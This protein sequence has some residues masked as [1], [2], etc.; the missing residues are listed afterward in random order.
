MDLESLRTFCLL[1]E[2]DSFTI[3]ARELGITE[4]T[5]SYRIKELEKYLDTELII[6]KRDRTIY[7]TERSIEL[8]EKSKG[9]LEWLDRF[10]SHNIRKPLKG[11]IKISSG[12]VAG[13]YFLASAVKDFRDK[14]PEVEI[15]LDFCSAEE[16]FTRLQNRE[17]DLGFSTSV[18]FKK[19]RNFINSTKVTEVFPIELIVI[20]PLNHPV[21][22]Y[23]K[24]EPSDILNYSYVARYENSAIQAEI[25]RI[26]EKSGIRADSLNVVYKF[27]NSSSVISAVTEGLGISICSKIQAIKYVHAGMIGYVPLKTDVKSYIYMIDRHKGENELVNIFD[28]YIRNYVK[29][30]MGTGVGL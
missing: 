23:E 26:F 21:L 25:D 19:F 3:T 16:T 28:S 12:E 29:I 22:S 13:I 2:N 10:K 30:L 14:H 7:F 18:N 20:A 8:Y 24:I 15:R 17:I 11:T 4:A 9:I 1:Y 6:R 27:P 5:V